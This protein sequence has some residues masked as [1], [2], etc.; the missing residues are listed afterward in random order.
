MERQ[1][2]DMA[3]I[4]GAALTAIRC[5]HCGEAHLVPEGNLPARCPLCLQGPVE[6]QPTVLRQEP[7]EQVIPYAVSGRQLA[8]ALEQW[9]R[10][11][12]FRP[13]ELR[14]DLL[15]QRAKRYYI[16]LWL[17]DGQVRGA[18]QAEVGFDYQVVSYQDRYSESGGWS[19]QQVNETRVRWEPRA[20]RIERRYD[21]LPTPALDD[22]RATI[23]RLGGVNLER[24]TDYQPEAVQDATVRIPT[25]DPDEA[26]PGAEAA[27]VRAAAAE[28]QQAASADHVRDFRLQAEYR[29]LNWSL[30]LLPAYV[31]WYQE[32]GRAWPVMVNGQSG[33][34]SG[35]RRASARK[36]NTTSLLLG[37]AALILFVIGSILALVGLAL[38]PVAVLGGFILVVGLLLALVAPIPAI[39][40]WIKN[41]KGE[42]THAPPLP[43]RE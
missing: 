43:A 7:P 16:P 26:W 11:I 30:L 27:F 15:L 41:R 14:A 29:D 2:V 21:N 3:A 38:P 4:W 37:S 42:A 24:R 9:T 18:W 31:T 10:G 34:I 19:S 32:G 22:H 13:R 33:H 23:G 36:A 17:V 1:S 12:W 25:L 40:V 5:A 28:C 39:G 6:A 8:A 20:G 35:A